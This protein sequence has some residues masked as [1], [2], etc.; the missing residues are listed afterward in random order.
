[1]R[2]VGILV[3][4]IM[5]IVILAVNSPKQPVLF[6]R[7]DDS[8]RDL[9]NNISY[10]LNLALYENVDSETNF[11]F[12]DSRF[13]YDF[14]PEDNVYAVEVAVSAARILGLEKEILEKYSL[15]SPAFNDIKTKLEK[16][17]VQK[18]YD[19]SR[20]FGYLEYMNKY[21]ISKIGLPLLDTNNPLNKL[22][23]ID[24]IKVIIKIFTV[25][26]LN[27]GWNF[28]YY[29]P[30]TNTNN[31]VSYSEKLNARLNINTG[32]NTPE[33]V[34]YLSVFE[35]YFLIKVEGKIIPVI[36][37]PYFEGDNIF[38]GNEYINRK[39]FYSLLA[40][41]FGKDPEQ[42]PDKDL[43]PVRTLNNMISYLPKSSLKGEP[44]L[45]EIKKPYISK[46]KSIEPYTFSNDVVKFDIENGELITLDNSKITV[47]TNYYIENIIENT[48]QTKTLKRQKEEYFNGKTFSMNY[49]YLDKKDFHKESFEFLSS[50]TI[51]K[52]NNEV[53]IINVN[54]EYNPKIKIPN[55]LVLAD[56]FKIDANNIKVKWYSVD[57]ETISKMRHLI[58]RR[59]SEIP[60]KYK[61][62]HKEVSAEE[63]PDAIGVLFKTNVDYIYRTKIIKSDYINA[64]VEYFKVIDR[65]NA[66]KKYA[67][68]SSLNTFLSNYNNYFEAVN[69]DEEHTF[70][71]YWKDVRNKLNEMKVLNEAY[72][73]PE[74]NVKIDLT[75]EKF[76][77]RP[78]DMTMYFWTFYG[79]KLVSFEPA[80]Y[81]LFTQKFV[82]PFK[83]SPDAFLYVKYKDGTIKS[84]KM[85]KEGKKLLYNDS[86]EYLRDMLLWFQIA[87]KVDE[88]GNQYME[89]VY[90][91]AE[92][93]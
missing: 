53:W 61:K 82:E 42:V 70:I 51:K 71:S 54:H 7:I 65:L 34:G 6:F 13:S 81:R 60:E 41:I 74:A 67:T 89:I 76:I 57:V 64:D 5:S 27:K 88:Y 1:M 55:N 63:I 80:T 46:I 3:F 45:F 52:N 18:G 75:E 20:N 62:L 33:D 11:S 48:S 15:S 16:S 47:K 2:K 25:E 72:F 66:E 24:V 4:L 58:K 50:G 68:L 93:I 37:L 28:G 79:G 49:K 86:E 10:L 23:K 22:K 32:I 29:I 8:I 43:I 90:V 12:F 9:P 87:L 92:E 83:F 39:Y 26:S 44:A 36:K 56:K 35:R 40:I 30:M 69:K 14:Y 21:F 91:I 78:K 84:G 19:F 17:Y 73:V 31:L 59:L 77:Q 38:D 85:S